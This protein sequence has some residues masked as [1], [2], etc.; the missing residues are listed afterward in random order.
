[1]LSGLSG[2]E[3]KFLEFVLAD[4]AWRENKPGRDKVFTGLGQ[5]AFTSRRAEEVNRLLQLSLTA[6]PWQRA[7]LLDGAGVKAPTKKGSPPL[8]LVRFKEEPVAWKKISALKDKETV[9]RAKN[10]AQLLTWPGKPGYVPPPVAKPF[11]PEE[12]ARFD[13]GK[14]L[15]AGTCAGCHQLSG[16]GMEGLAPP[17][18]DSEWV[19]GSD[20]RLS[21]I[22]LLGVRG[23]IKVGG[24]TYSLEMPGL[25]ASFNDEQIASILTY[26]RREWEHVGN[27]VQPVTVNKQR[28]KNAKRTEAW[29]EAELLKIP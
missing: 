3:N 15:F 23:P 21:Q 18:V 28:A 27:P 1:V 9:D 14:Q 8:K 20:S 19:L 17:L 2:R 26:I 5:C 29:S 16:L 10:V 7:A 25:A 13:T 22:V 24:R 6:T 11:T 12:Q 4:N